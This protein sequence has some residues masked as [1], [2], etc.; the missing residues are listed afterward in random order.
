M[1]Y[2]TAI[3]NINFPKNTEQATLPLQK[4]EIFKPARNA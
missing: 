4:G 2:P 1:D 3:A